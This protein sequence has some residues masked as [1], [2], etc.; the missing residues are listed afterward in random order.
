MG[1]TTNKAFRYPE[2]TDRVADGAAAMQ[3][4]AEDVDDAWP[5]D[6]DS[7]VR[8]DGGTISGN[9]TTGSPGAWLTTPSGGSTCA[10]SVTV[11]ASGRVLIA[12]RAEVINAAGPFVMQVGVRLNGAGLSNVDPG[13]SATLKFGCGSAFQDGKGMSYVRDGLTPGATLTATMIYRIFTSGTTESMTV[14]ERRID[15]VPLP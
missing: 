9:G 3:H 7:D 8:S 14:D 5:T 4:L 15:L 1:T 2:A 12:Y 13:D 11:P 10:A 6:P